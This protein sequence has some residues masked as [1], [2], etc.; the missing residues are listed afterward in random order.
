MSSSN[1]ACYQETP[2]EKKRKVDPNYPTTVFHPEMA[3][4]LVEE[5]VHSCNVKGIIDLTMGPGTWAKVA[6]ERSIPYF[7]V[8][9]SSLHKT[10]MFTYLEEHTRSMTQN[11]ASPLYLGPRNPAPKPAAKPKPKPKP[12]A[13]PQPATG[14]ASPAQSSGSDEE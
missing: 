11:E 7:G 10:S 5:F 2:A 3:P 9:L 6:V 4:A 1:P 8:A 13:E 12:K 14:D